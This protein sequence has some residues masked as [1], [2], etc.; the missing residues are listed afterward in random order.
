MSRGRG[1]ETREPLHREPHEGDSAFH[2]LR[3]GSS[4]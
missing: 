1:E 3:E 4:A 2:S